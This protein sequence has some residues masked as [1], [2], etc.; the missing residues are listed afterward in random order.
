MNKDYIPFGKEWE[1][2]LMRMTKLTISVIFSVEC[3]GTKKEM[4]EAV[5]HKLRQEE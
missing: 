4:I 5:R 2:E 1:K 3:K